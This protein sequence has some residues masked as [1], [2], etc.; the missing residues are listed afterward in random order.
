MEKIRVLISIVLMGL[1]V[2]EF[3]YLQ[4]RVIRGIPIH[5]KYLAKASL[6]HAR[7]VIGRRPEPFL[8]P[9]YVTE[10]MPMPSPTAANH[11]ELGHEI[12]AE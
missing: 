12:E 9:S 1:C 10:P 11:E 4:G 7:Q 2:C 8:L 3:E 5:S 6:I